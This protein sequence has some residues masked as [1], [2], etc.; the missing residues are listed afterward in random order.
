MRIKVG[1]K[2]PFSQKSFAWQATLTKFSFL[3]LATFVCGAFWAEAFVPPSYEV[4]HQ[5]VKKNNALESSRFMHKVTFYNSSGEILKS[6]R[7]DFYFN[8]EQA[9]I[10]IQNENGHWV[11]SKVQ[12]FQK[13]YSPLYDLL[14]SNKGA[15][16]FSHLRALGLALRS[17]E[18][19]Y[20]QSMEQFRES[21][22]TPEMNLFF[23]RYGSHIV[24]VIRD[25][26]WEEG[27]PELWVEKDSYFPLKLVLPSEP[28]GQMYEYR[29]EHFQPYETFFYPRLTHVLKDGNLWVTME[30]KEIKL[31]EPKAPEIPGKAFDLSSDIDS[32]IQSHLNAYLKWIR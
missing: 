11:A 4:I 15:K 2:R 26:R 19:N 17:E 29:M 1:L 16:A 28:D 12:N 8:Q 14:F 9:L 10:R 18:E 30:T 24:E 32:D 6:F 20:Q 13:N 7:E 27:D 23:K 31:S 5:I 25:S 3:F 22:F 21:I